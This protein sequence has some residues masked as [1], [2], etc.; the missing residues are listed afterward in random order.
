MAKT[1]QIP[2]ELWAALKKHFR[3]GFIYEDAETEIEEE[4]QAEYNQREEYIKLLIRE[5]DR[6]MMLRE[7]YR[8]VAQAKNK[9]TEE[10]KKAQQFYDRAR[11]TL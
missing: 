5:K 6:K 7:A 4:S 11:K 8:P 10:K 9:S 1:V 3:V 2:I